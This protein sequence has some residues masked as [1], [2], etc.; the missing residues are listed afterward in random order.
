[1]G[2]KSLL[3]S[4]ILIS[5]SAFSQ[6]NVTITASKSS[7]T[8]AESID[9]VA[10]IEEPT[11]K[12]IIINFNYSGTAKNESDF[13]FNFPSKG[14]ISAAAG[15]YGHGT[16]ANQFMGTLGAVVDKDGN[17]YVSDYDNHRVQKWAP[18]ATE[19]ITVAGGNGWGTAPNQLCLP[20]GLFIDENNNLYIANENGHNVQKWAP[21][22]TVGEIV[23]GGN[24]AGNQP[25]QLS[26]PTSVFV[27]LSGNVFV[28]DYGN[29]RIQKWAPGANEGVTVAG[30]NGRGSANNQFNSPVDMHVDFQG[31]L[32]VADLQN[33][34][35]QKFLPGSTVGITVAG[36][37]SWGA[38]ADQFQSP[39]ALH[40]DKDGNIFVA[41]RHNNRIQK[42][43]L[44]A[45]T[46][47]TIAQGDLGGL[48]PEKFYPHDIF[49]D[50]AGNIY[51]AD[52]NHN[53]VMK[54]QYAPQIIIK[55]GQTTGTLTLSGI[56]DELIEEKETVILTP[57]NVVNG[58]LTNPGNIE[59]SIG[60][61]LRV[62]FSFS[63]PRIME[64]SPVD[65][66]MTASVNE[67]SNN[68]IQIDFTTEG[69]ATE[70]AEYILSSKTITIPAGGETG[71]LTISTNGLDDT[72]SEILESIILKVNSITNASA[73]SNTPTVYI[74]SD[75]NPVL[76]ISTSSKTFTESGSIE[77]IATLQEPTDKVVFID[78]DYTGTAKEGVDYN[79]KL[80]KLGEPFTVAGGN[81]N[82]SKSDQINP[83]GVHV[84]R[85]GNIYI[86][87]Y[88]NHRIQ[89][90]APGAITGKTVAGGNGPGQ[91]ANQLNYPTRVLVDD[92]GN[93]YVSDGSNHRIQKWAP[94]ATEGITVAGGNGQGRAS[95]QL[96]NPYGI[97]LDKAGNLYVAD[98]S[99]GRIQ[100]FAPQS[101]SG[102][103]VAG[104][105][106]IFHEPQDIF[107]DDEGNIFVADSYNHRIV[108]WVP[109]APSGKVI[110]PSVN[111]PNAIALD[112]EGNIYVSA[113]NSILRYPSENQ[114]SSQSLPTT[115]AGGPNVGSAPEWLN[116]PFDLF[117]DE[118]G[119]IYVADANNFRV[120][121]YPYASQFMVLPGE[122]SRKLTLVGVNDNLDKDDKTIVIS[123]V[124][125]ENA[126]L[127]NNSSQ[128]IA[129]TDDDESP[130]VTFALSGA[131]MQESWYNQITLT[132]TL[133]AVSGKDIKI[134]LKLGGTAQETTE[135]TVNTKSLVIPAG[136]S[137]GII[138]ISPAPDDNLVEPL[139]SIEF[140]I[141]T[142]IN[143]KS[144]AP[145]PILWI[146]SDDLPSVSLEAS[147]T[148]I[149]EHQGLDIIATLDAPASNDV[150]VDLA[151]TGSAI[152]DQDYV[153]EFETKGTASSYA[154][155]GQ[156]YDSHQLSFPHGIFV[157]S[158]DNL[159]VADSYNYRVQKWNPNSILAYTV[160]G[161]GNYGT[162]TSRLG[163]PMSVFVDQ[164]KNIY[165]AD[166][167]NHRVVKWAPG[168]YSGVI[169]AG[170][171]GPGSNSNQLY[172]PGGIYV[173]ESGNV[174]VA[175]DAN[176]RIQKWAPGASTGVTV[177]GGNGQGSDPHQLHSPTDIV[178]DN[179]GTL[180]ISDVGN[181]RIQKWL[182]GA[183]SGITI[184]GHNWGS[185]LNQFHNPTGLDLDQAG[186]LYVADQVNH[187][188][189][190]FLPGASEGVI[191]GGGSFGTDPDQLNYPYDVCVDKGGNVYVSDNTN[192]RIQ[193][194]QYAPQ[195]II[196]AGE[197]TGKLS[198]IG[199]NDELNNEGDETITVKS[200][201]ITYGI[202]SIR[203]VNITL[204]DN[205][206]T[207]TLEENPFP[208][209]L[210]GAVTW[211]DYDRDGD[212]DVAVMGQSP[213]EGTVTAVYENQ[214]G[215][216]IR[217]VHVFE[218][219]YK[220]DISWV[221]VNKDGWI[222]L[223]VSGYNEAPMT[224]LYLNAE[225]KSFTPTNDYGLPQLFDTRMAWGDLDNDGDI[226]LAISGINKNEEFVIN[227]YNR[228]DNEDR[229]ILDEFTGNEPEVWYG[230]INGDL[231]IEDVDMDGDNDVIYSGENI[232]KQCWG[233]IYYN[234]YIENPYREKDDYFLR[235][236]HSSIEAARIKTDQN[237]LTIIIN[238]EDFYGNTLLQSNH[239]LVFESKDAQQVDGP[240]LKN[241]DIAV[242]DYNTDGLND[243]VFTGEDMLGLPVTKLFSQNKSGRFKES[244][245]TLNGLRNSTADW[246]DY[247]MDGDLD[248]F[249][250][251]EDASGA[252]TLLYK[253]Q[254][255]NKV[256]MPPSVIAGLKT[257]HLGNGK[258]RFS[259]EKP[260]D[261]FSSNLGYV[262][263]IGTT[264]GGSEL[265]NTESDLET[266][267]RLISKPASIYNNFYE[268][269][270]DPGNYFWSVQ[271]IDP[272]LKGGAFSQEDTFIL[273]YEWKILNQGG[274]I[275]RRIAGIKDPVI[276]LGDIDND[277]DMDLIYGSEFDGQVK[278][279]KYDGK[280]LRVTRDNLFANVQKL[281]DVEVGDLNG[282]GTPDI[283]MNNAANDGTYSLLLYL[284]TTDG[285]T[286]KNL[287]SGLYKAKGKIIDLN[288]DGKV[289]AVII[290]SSS[291]L[292]SGKLKM[293]IH[294][295]TP[296]TGTF[297][298]TDV[299]S[300]LTSITNASFDLGDIDN[301][302]DIDLILNG[303]SSSN[304]YQC[305]I[306]KN[307]SE[308]GGSYNFTSTVNSIA[309]VV[310]GT[311]DLIDIDGD[312]DLDLVITG[313]SKTGDVF[314]I[315]ENQLVSGSP[316]FV[317]FAQSGMTPIR[318][319][320]VDLGDFNGDG[321]S[322]LL[323]SGTV[324]GVG[325]ITGLSEYNPSSKTYTKSSFDVSDIINAS[326][327]FGDF[328]GDGDL[329]F[330]ISGESSKVLNSYIFRAYINVRNESATV[331]AS[332]GSRSLNDFVVNASPTTPV[333]IGVKVL[334]ALPDGRLLTEFSW[335]ESNDDHT[336]GKGLTY[337]LKVG[338]TS[339]GDEIM[340]PN[341][342]L[343]G[344][345][346]TA[347]KGNVEH[348]LK[349]RLA[350]P[351]GN[352]YWSVQAI[353]A[354]YAGSAFSTTKSVS[355]TVG[356]DDLDNDKQ[357]ITYPNPTS[358]VFN[359]IIPGNEREVKVS[360]RNTTGSIMQQSNKQ[361]PNDRK[362]NMNISTLEPGVYFVSVQSEEMS[363]VVKVVKK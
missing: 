346:K 197:T 61:T 232:Y 40:V 64:N 43:A 341:A 174:Y 357:L 293:I 137:K 255:I 265:S 136:T 3:L 102:I 254:T 286:L 4:L 351:K 159:Y 84:D 273:T 333:P 321:Y 50:E 30:G 39:Y 41:D 59:F 106:G 270:L 37:N 155:H 32:F 292:V 246:V 86:C 19:G 318:S 162:S 20:R 158:D 201:F 252:K 48:I 129:L 26:N 336:P 200:K 2:S 235:F 299:S 229:F 305:F 103:T 97:F 170:G 44:N 277:N 320:K 290:G 154:G 207:L 268:T 323:Y 215:S 52:A 34:R 210:N 143:A 95:N 262:I 231:K 307:I 115:I 349:W 24:G 317:K 122:T 334:N 140:I 58:T 202:D 350:L 298:S 287:G 361:V 114:L 301:D 228:D 295:Y 280:H 219:L 18:G 247:D 128:T 272:G 51:S 168:A 343:N 315:Y 223:V 297:T 216:F 360:I 242:A 261:D 71:T 243:I 304:G 152:F 161:D 104:G 267:R 355:I 16:A 284:S 163:H 121:K 330:A 53:I 120:Q 335:L 187:R 99:N 249:L 271:A 6:N 288:N 54:F 82:G 322:D 70:T 31:N 193:K 153:I 189:L 222:D 308:A 359:I 363:Y 13:S 178:L 326:V 56:S 109:G 347:K 130:S 108:K 123:P 57:L 9:I 12:D 112:K 27:D 93:V 282:D 125:V 35:I 227:V 116:K 47:I 169:V 181:A 259:W 209:L 166:L 240:K 294:E 69:T 248:L 289:E 134:D 85:D 46:G 224:K 212:H 88:S 192:H 283:L 63:A 213:T 156:G 55:A 328:E 113:I 281:T 180:Y 195:I 105:S 65:V 237:D 167:G 96:N 145:V 279:L 230:I 68:D 348:N 204:H 22:A 276:K 142:I 220:G 139:E 14:F 203:A 8:E 60:N 221:D 327:E 80:V 25:N 42:W 45:S 117:I 233:G 107:V 314:D 344:I 331:L 173:D 275:D 100:R 49:L 15:G 258:V 89:K 342:N 81:G 73:V 184:A 141:D 358:G 183:T 185:E 23:A 171:N 257:E 356:I 319:G 62:S 324:G 296:L 160:A 175:D 214:N 74:E 132:A 90:W 75:D 311:S 285:F 124:K 198:L 269:H 110:I 325:R 151:L 251:G 186:N 133:S 236:K 87:D 274:I 188:V 146:E 278:L 191:V 225:G 17:V 226:D 118:M 337:A 77:V 165:V 253:S 218:K 67:V 38:N 94:G 147:L 149:A 190:K 234:T 126:V 211:G 206:T 313:T 91:N 256:N 66:I 33:Y 21:G 309:A 302:L 111:N 176:N 306:Y 245:I 194:Y 316:S 179:T 11:D 135:Y 119:S 205:S 352:Y 1:M 83:R 164:K 339:N 196:K 332:A 7:M 127:D 29:E 329:D 300:Q 76:K 250:T 291:N 10:S 238:G 266:G 340:S 264:P 199:Q 79:T 28:A 78:L 263:R 36:G 148:T 354:S 208:G 310:D 150:I 157:D 172:N 144:S 92:S 98:R 101:T 312:G 239:I 345:R 131:K 353:D 241:G 362:L 217:T 177:A 303:Y 138:T 260:S 338:K 244:D 182:P 72:R 5:F